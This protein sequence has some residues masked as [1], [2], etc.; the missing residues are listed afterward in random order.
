MKKAEW[1]GI[2]SEFLIYAGEGRVY[3]V[4]DGEKEKQFEAGSFTA[5]VELIEK[6]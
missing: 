2:V 4:K 1:V 3:A 6:Q 5:L